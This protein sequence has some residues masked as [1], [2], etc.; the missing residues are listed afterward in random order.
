M[1]RARVLAREEPGFATWSRDEQ[2]DWIDDMAAQQLQD[3]P[4]SFWDDA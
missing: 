2:G 4:P 3:M 1:R